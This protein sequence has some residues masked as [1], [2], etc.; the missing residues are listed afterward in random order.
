MLKL[1]SVVDYSIPEV[2]QGKPMACLSR[3]RV[4][5]LGPLI[6][7]VD[8]ALFAPRYHRTNEISAILSWLLRGMPVLEELSLSHGQYSNFHHNFVLPDI[9]QGLRSAPFLSANSTSEILISKPRRCSHLVLI[10][11]PLSPSL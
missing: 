6:P 2:V 3:L 5:F 10:P 8:E 4:F 9:G 11:T 7:Y 1:P